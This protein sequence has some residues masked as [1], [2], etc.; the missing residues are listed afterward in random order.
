MAG[1]RRPLV[2]AGGR[3]GPGPLP[4]R[5]PATDALGAI[6]AVGRSAARIVGPGR[7]RLGRPDTGPVRSVRSVS[8]SSALVEPGLVTVSAVGA[9]A[10]S[11]AV[12]AAR[13]PPGPQGPA[14]WTPPAGPTGPTSWAPP[15]GAPPGYPASKPSN[16][17][18]IASLVLGIIGV[19]SFWLFIGGLLGVIGLV[20]GIIG[21]KK[22][23]RI[24]NGKGISIAG[25]ILSALAIIGTIVMIAAV[26][27]LIDNGEEL[28]GEAD[29]ST[30]DVTL[31]SCSVS[32]GEGVAFG[33]ITNTDDRERRFVVLVDI[34][35][36]GSTTNSSTFVNLRPGEDSTWQ[37]SATTSAAEVT[38]SEPEVRRALQR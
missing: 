21:I 33:T 16:G 11:R 22:A 3:A 34:T 28:F 14:P 10:G 36:D 32:N 24:D 25:T 26:A 6:D 7:S 38:C 31:E 29:P 18:G 15:G 1:Q 27:W 5:S 2:S 30:Y 9:P 35:G 8:R 13:P 17:P 12:G 20:L 23:R 19:L 4:G 37:V